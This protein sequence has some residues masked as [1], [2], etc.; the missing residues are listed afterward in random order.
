MICF[1]KMHNQQKFKME[2]PFYRLMTIPRS[3][4]PLVIV[5]YS[6]KG[7]IITITTKNEELLNE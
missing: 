7:D 4:Y 6:S 3:M 5:F 1:L 2:Y